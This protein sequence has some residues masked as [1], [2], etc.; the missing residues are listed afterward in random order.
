MPLVARESSVVI[1]GSGSQILACTVPGCED[2]LFM[3]E[4]AAEK[5]TE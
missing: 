4:I 3:L 5:L 2:F 1:D